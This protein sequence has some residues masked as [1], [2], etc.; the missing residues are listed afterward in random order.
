MCFPF[1]DTRLL[2]TFMSDNQLNLND[3][4]CFQCEMYL[5][6]VALTDCRKRRDNILL[7][8]WRVMCFQF[9]N[10]PSY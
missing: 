1:R 3:G 8:D 4:T 10:T 9:R 6:I 5:G 7:N 2:D